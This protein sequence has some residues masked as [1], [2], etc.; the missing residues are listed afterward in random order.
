M[1]AGPE[2]VGVGPGGEELC[3]NCDKPLAG[4]KLYCS[5][6]CAEEAKTI[7][8]IRAVTR[9]GRIEQADI[10]EAVKIRMAMLL[11]GGYPRQQRRVAPEVR[12]AVF[13]RDGHSCQVCGEP[14]SEIHHLDHSLTEGVNEAD[15]LQ[16][17][18]SSCHRKET[19]SKFKPA[20]EE[21]KKRGRIYQLRIAAPEP[22]RL[23]DDEVEWPK[24]YRRLQ[25]DRRARAAA[26]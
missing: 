3:F 14:A 15:N 17:L 7:R 20:S 21:Q 8:Y 10:A 25:A 13:Q 11:G 12:A 2:L 4:P 22:L 6:L 5:S 19:M 16:A 1:T 9:D 26:A 23:S 24:R 18:C